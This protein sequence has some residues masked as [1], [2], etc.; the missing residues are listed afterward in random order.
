[1]SR[2]DAKHFDE[3]QWNDGRDA[4]IVNGT[5]IHETAGVTFPEEAERDLLLGVF[6]AVLDRKYCPYCKTGLEEADYDYQRGKSFY[7]GR[8]V[9]VCPNC[10]YWHYN[11]Y[12]ACD[13]YIQSGIVRKLCVGKLRHY[14]DGLPTSCNKEIAQAIR[15]NP[16]FWAHFNPTRLEKFVADL[17]R[18]NFH[19]AEV[20]HVGRP[21]DGGVDVLFIDAGS[22]QWLVQVKRRTDLFQS[23]GVETLRNLMGAMLERDIFKGVVVS[24]ADHF[25]TYACRLA[26]EMSEKS[27]TIRMFDRG[28]L[29]RMIGALLPTQP[30]LA[31]VHRH[32]PRLVK[33]FSLFWPEGI[34]RSLVRN[35]LS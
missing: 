11:K 27:V 23:E 17:F 1:M 16:G 9:V 25:T 26:K 18:A 15:R 33:H 24:T 3:I 31:A 4:R 13:D 14:R 12:A 20:I 34:G 30:W 35:R 32:N 28:V 2:F 7:F 8:T 10:A 19:H 5:D 22:K 21:N 6:H 29:H